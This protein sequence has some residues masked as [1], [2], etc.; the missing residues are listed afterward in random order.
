MILAEAFDQ[1]KRE[2]TCVNY[3]W[4]VYVTVYKTLN[5]LDNYEPLL[6][7]YLPILDR[8]IHRN[9]NI[10]SYIDNLEIM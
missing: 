9:S 10:D 8:L 7:A 6:V 2:S 1:M 4:A 5:I 3:S